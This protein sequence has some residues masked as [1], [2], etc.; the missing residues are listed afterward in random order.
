MWIKYDCRR[1]KCNRNILLFCCLRA[2]IFGFFLVFQNT[3]NTSLAQRDGRK[4]ARAACRDFI[5][6][7][8]TLAWPGSDWS[9]GGE[10]G[11][12]L[13]QIRVQVRPACTGCHRKWLTEV[14]AMF[15]KFL[16]WILSNFSI[17]KDWF[18]IL[19]LQLCAPKLWEVKYVSFS[20][21]TFF[22]HG[23]FDK[24]LTHY[25]ILLTY[26]TKK[27]KCVHFRRKWNKFYPNSVACR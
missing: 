12:S 6:L 7:R 25:V 24:I 26:D 2:I 9:R 5:L 8:I 16:A 27:L 14:S 15:T 18:V 10:S 17:N 13:V 4:A 21:E 23:I 11:L 3:Q 19:K 1:H 22:F 20:A